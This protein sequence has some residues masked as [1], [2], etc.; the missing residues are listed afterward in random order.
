MKR[1]I[2]LVVALL[3]VLGATALTTRAALPTEIIAPSPAQSSAQSMVSPPGQSSTQAQDK[4]ISLNSPLVVRATHSDTSRPLREIRPAPMS[5]SHARKEIERENFYK[6]RNSA[7]PRDAVD[8]VVQT[9]FGPLAMP[10]PILTFEGYRQQDNYNNNNGLG[11]LPPDTNGDIGPNHYFQW[12]NIGLRIFDRSGNTVYGP[13]NGN[14]LFDAFTPVCSAQNDGDPIVLYDT[15]AGR[16]LASQFALPTGASGPSYQCIAISTTS[17]PTGS[18][19]RYEFQSSPTLFEDYPHF[20]VWPDLDSTGGYNGGAY[21]MATNE[22]SSPVTFA[23]AGFFAF[24]RKKM[25]N[26]DATATMQYFHLESPYGGFLPSDMDGPTP[27]P[28]GR[29][30]YFIAVE[31]DWAAPPF[32]RLQMYKFRANFDNPALS[33]FVGPFVMEVASFDSDLCT[34]TR[35]A[36]IPQ[37]GTAQRLEAISDRLMY[38]LAYRN[39]GTHESLVVNHTVDADGAGRAG[40]RWYELRNPEAQPAPTVYQQSTY[41]PDGDHR[42]MGSI[43]MDAQGN[44]ALGYSVSNGTNLFPTIRYTG[45]LVTDPLNQMAQ[46]ETTMYPGGGHQTHSSGRWGDY[47]MMG[48]DPMDDCTFWYTQE[49]MPVSSSANWSSRIGAFKFPGCVSAGG[50]ATPVATGTP[51]LITVTPQ[52]ATATLTAQIATN[53]PTASST[54]G[55]GATSTPG[56]KTILYDQYNQPGLTGSPSF[57]RSGTFIQ[58]ADDFVVPAGDRWEISRVD[59]DGFYDPATARATSLNLYFYSDILS[60]TVHMPGPAIITQTNIIPLAGQNTGEF[61]VPVSPTVSLNAGAYWV[62]VQANHDS[63]RW[64]WLNRQPPP[65]NNVATSRNPADLNPACQT[66]N[67]RGLCVAGSGGEPDQV[68]RLNGWRYMVGTTPTVAV[69]AISS[70]TST[71]I[72][73]VTVAVGTT[74]ATIAVSATATAPITGTVGASVTPTTTQAVGTSTATIGVGTSTATQVTGTTTAIASTTATVVASATRTA[75]ATS[76]VVASS[77]SVLPSVTIVPPTSTATV[78]VGTSTAT[79][80]ASVT[81]T[82]TVGVTTTIVPPTSTRTGTS[83]VPSATIVPP[84]STAT[85]GVGTSTATIPASAT[86]TATVGVTTTVVPPTATRTIVSTATG[87]AMPSMTS[88]VGVTMTGTAVVTR[89]G[90]AM[91]SMTATTMATGTSTMMPTRTAV[92]CN[93]RVT[94]CHRTGNGNSHSISISC[95]ALPA[96]M[97]HGDTMG[98]CASA[99]PPRNN[100]FRDVSGG[101]YFYEHTLD[102][103]DAQ[104][105]GGYDDGT[106]RPYN[107]A[108]RAQ[109]VKIVVLAFHIPLYAGSDQSFS[110]VPRD[111]PFYQYIMTAKRDNIISGYNDGTFRPYANVTRGQIAKIAVESARMADLS[112]EGP[113]FRDVEPGSTFYRYIETAYAHGILSGYADGTFR[114]FNDATRGQITKIVNLATHPGETQR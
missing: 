31:D 56:P 44:M 110:D 74:T 73:T 81:R 63:G 48:I 103:R 52:L 5:P 93:G 50:T 25:L 78:G 34:A 97:R 18:Y 41:S 40:V 68:F 61:A 104:A 88:T 33:T 60:G 67:V 95:S 43:S 9:F 76:S 80:P 19:H 24:D 22:F 4:P 15:V 23:G 109:L 91:P 70:A 69:T 28:P 38:R 86:R 10:T 30:N 85:V 45:R 82:A 1:I 53:T 84:T 58:L 37:P 75:L 106:F 17:D 114:P 64:L 32:D 6:P 8:T 54:P 96:H 65:S 66:W 21:Y 98:E 27:P 92:P 20:G 29:P 35:E 62:S 39:F 111:H 7:P 94:V 105:I 90:T 102:L 112:G 107:Q 3:S 13:V 36:C 46:G 72:P 47:S 113:S 14:T 11:V 57:V 59:V 83:V 42:W 100:P 77:T 71:A 87:T 108:T 49:Y 101:D 99:P 79:I 26:G 16:W 89:T 51:P 55:S 2:A 12:N